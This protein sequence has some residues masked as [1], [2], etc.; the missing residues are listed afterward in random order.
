MRIHG[1]RQSGVANLDQN[2]APRYEG[3]RA[4]ATFGDGVKRTKAQADRRSCSQ[5]QY[6]GG[7]VRLPLTVC[8]YL[9]ELFPRS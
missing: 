3:S 7:C 1:Y 5:V 9:I 8:F 4:S 6:G 2:N